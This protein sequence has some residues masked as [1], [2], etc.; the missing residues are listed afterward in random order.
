MNYKYVDYYIKFG[1]NVAY[2]RKLKNMTQRELAD[3]INA[4][5]SHISKIENGHVGMSFDRLFDICEALGVQPNKLLE[6][7]D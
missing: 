6:F 4:E 7:R 2:Y 1:L 3:S 5:I